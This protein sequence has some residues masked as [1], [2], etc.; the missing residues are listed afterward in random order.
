MSGAAHVFR[1]PAGDVKMYAQKN[2]FETFRRVVHE[3]KLES[4]LV[5]KTLGQSTAQ[6]VRRQR[7]LLRKLQL[8]EKVLQQTR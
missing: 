3:S 7:A 6:R 5:E 2:V 1:L 4:L 8:G